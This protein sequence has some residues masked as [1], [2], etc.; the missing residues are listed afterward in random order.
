MGNSSRRALART[1]SHNSSIVVANL[2]VSLMKPLRPGPFHFS[3][4]HWRSIVGPSELRRKALDAG[5]WR[6]A[7]R[8]AA[9]LP[10]A[11]WP[12]GDRGGHYD[13]RESPHPFGGRARGFGRIPACKSR[14]AR[15]ANRRALGRG[16]RGP[17]CRL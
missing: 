10:R 4:R 17:T 9:T 8:F 16:G 5:G 1:S 14:P 2:L 13:S 15:R 11:T 7:P 3:K 6:P 12:R